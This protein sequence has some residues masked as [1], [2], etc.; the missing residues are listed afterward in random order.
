[1]RCE[2]SVRPIF[3]IFIALLPV[4]SSVAV[5]GAD[6]NIIVIRVENL[7]TDGRAQLA[8]IHNFLGVAGK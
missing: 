1:M 6:N 5:S 7:A 4:K 2:K 3:L 8:M